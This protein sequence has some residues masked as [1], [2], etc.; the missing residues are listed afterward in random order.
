MILDSK[1]TVDPRD[2][3]D[4]ARRRELVEFA[5]ANGLTDID[6]NMPADGYDGIRHLL[7]SKGITRIIIPPRK[8]GAQAS[9]RTFP[10]KPHKPAANSRVETD[11]KVKIDADELRSFRAWQAQQKKNKIA[12]EKP[13]GDMSI[14]ELRQAC[15]AKGIKL[16]RTDNIA[17]L[18]AKLNG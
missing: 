10:L 13:V 14:G 9:E 5:Q 11:P 3:L 1:R 16:A 12:A 2:N 15:K 18:R 6:E 7:R 17:S 8:L 4:K